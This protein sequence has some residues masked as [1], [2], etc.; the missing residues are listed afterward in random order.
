MDFLTLYDCNLKRL[1][2]G[3]SN[4]GGYVVFD[5]LNYDGFVSAGIDNNNVFENDVLKV[6]GLKECYAFDNSIEEIPQK[7]D[8]IRFEKR[9]IDEDFNMS[10]II[11]KYDS[12]F[13]KVDIEGSEWR[14]L[15]SLEKDIMN[16][17]N[18]LVIEFHFLI[19]LDYDTRKN[20][21][22]LLNTFIERTNVMKRLNETHVLCHIHSNNYADQLKYFNKELPTVF[23]CTY[24][25]KNVFR[26]N[27]ELILFK[28]I[29]SLPTPFD[30]PNYKQ[31]DDITNHLNY[32]P[33]VHMNME[34][35][36]L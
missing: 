26:N 2:L 3:T 13:V 6:F 30:A 23:E 35:V 16:K 19:D 8:N 32:E 22:T 21:S 34:V 25:N 11:N 15:S 4:D 36:H 31:M 10:S 24:L 17:I 1:R 18:Q 29:R 28:N 12:C 33:F 20:P 27:S 9:T 5:G 14:W 7:N